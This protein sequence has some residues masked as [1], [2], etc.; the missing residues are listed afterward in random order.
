M[1]T[2]CGASWRGRALAGERQRV[3]AEGD[4]AQIEEAA[5]G[6]HRGERQGEVRH[7]PAPLPARG[8]DQQRGEGRAVG[9]ADHLGADGEAH[10]GAGEQR[11]PPFRL[12]Q[13]AQAEGSG[14]EQAGG[15]EDVDVLCGREADH[16]RRRHHEKR[17]ER[18]VAPRAEMA[19]EGSGR[20]AQQQPLRQE[21]QV[22]VQLAVRRCHPPP[23]P[24]R[25]VG[26]R[27]AVVAHRIR[28][29]DRLQVVVLAAR[30]R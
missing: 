10:P 26:R 12:A 3:D 24:D 8:D 4:I 21:C 14:G 18:P 23:G 27:V 1:G 13:P 15:G 19:G 25:A 6:R 16:H 2:A 22:D 11:A 7:P 28:P 17:G 20:E 29:E 5:Q 9:D 30:W